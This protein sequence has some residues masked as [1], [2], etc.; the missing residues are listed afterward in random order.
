MWIQKHTYIATLSR[1]TLKTEFSDENKLIKK[2]K[3]IFV[4]VAAISVVGKE[5]IVHEASTAAATHHPQS[6]LTKISVAVTSQ[7]KQVV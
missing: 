5:A 6:M 2:K 3:L 1:S 7:A 4:V